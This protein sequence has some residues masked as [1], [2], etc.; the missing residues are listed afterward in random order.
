MGKDHT[1]YALKNGVVTFQK[2]R[3]NK[4]YVSVEEAA[5]N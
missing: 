4:S 1:L 3:D 2:K 5:A